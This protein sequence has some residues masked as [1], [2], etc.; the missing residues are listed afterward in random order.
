MGSEMCIRDSLYVGGDLYVKDDI[1]YDQ[2]SGRE[3]S[4][5]G[6]G[7]ISS[8]NADSI[9]A[10]SATITTLNA[11]T[12]TGAAQVAVSSEGTYIGSGA[13]VINFASSNTT[14]WT[15]SAPSAGV[16]TA[17]VTPGASLG[18]VLALGG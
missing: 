10:T 8:F 13:S 5:S 12:I 14:A 3:L 6:V 7:T 17:T 2:V 18:M 11:G 4:I 9:V 1:T 16:A 15:V